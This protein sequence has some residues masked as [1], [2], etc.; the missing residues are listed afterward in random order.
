MREE[1][2]YQSMTLFRKKGTKADPNVPAGG[3]R[4][5]DP[6]AADSPTPV[7]PTPEEQE[8]ESLAGALIEAV[9]RQNKPD[10]KELI[11][12]GADVN[13]TRFDEAPLHVAAERGFD[14]EAELLI[15][16]GAD[17]NM[18]DGEGMTPLMLAARRGW[19]AE[20]L[21][22]AG[23]DVNATHPEGKAALHFAAEFSNPSVVEQLI[24]AGADVHAK[25]ARGNTPAHYAFMS[26]EAVRLLRAAGADFKGKNKERRTATDLV[27]GRAASETQPGQFTAIL[28]FLKSGRVT[29]R[30]G[31]QVSERWD[32]YAAASVESAGHRVRIEAAI[33][34]RRNDVVARGPRPFG[35]FIIFATKENAEHIAGL[36]REAG[37]PRVDVRQ[38]SF[39]VDS[40]GWSVA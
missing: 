18:P 37:C 12:Q 23:A 21:I 13:G 30:T 1:T 33:E 11:A 19:G 20:R 38:A 14:I 32:D 16:A 28:E 9:K 24:G 36:L 2:R 4:M 39:D 6:P 31:W 25:D 29:K 22:V 27:R 7:P 8:R 5:G 10:L 34:E 17:V 26:L 3:K 35:S 40:G 15:A